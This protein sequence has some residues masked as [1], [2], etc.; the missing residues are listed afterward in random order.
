MFQNIRFSGSANNVLPNLSDCS[1]RCFSCKSNQASYLCRFSRDWGLV[2]VCLCTICM[3]LDIEQLVK[4][5]LKDCV[6]G[7]P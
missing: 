3:E 1:L 7:T 6:G 4:E 5:V 2:Q